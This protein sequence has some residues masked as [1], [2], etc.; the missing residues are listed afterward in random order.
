MLSPRQRHFAHSG[1]ASGIAFLLSELAGA[2]VT[3]PNGTVVPNLMPSPDYTET[4]IQAYFAESGETID[5]VAE[6]LA[7]PGKFSPLCNFEASLVLTVSNAEAG[8]AWYNVDEADATRPMRDD[9]LFHILAPSNV[10][11]ASISAAD[12]RNDLAYAGGYVGFAL[13]KNLDQDTS[14]PPTA[15]YYSEYRR[16]AECTAC[17]EPGHWKMALSFA[18]S[19]RSD[20]YYLAFEDWEGANDT[21]WFGNDGDFNDKV[22]KLVGISCAGGGMPC[23]TGGIGLC[24][25]GKTECAFDGGAP[26]CVPQYEAEDEL[27]DNVD[28]DCNGLVDDGQLCATNYACVRGTCVPRCQ[29]GEFV[30]PPDLNCSDDGY[31]FDPLCVDVICEANRTCRGGE[32]IDACSGIVCPLGQSCINGECKRACDGVICAPGS[33]CEGGVCIGT[34]GCTECLDGRICAPSGH[35]VDPGCETLTC[36]EGT[37]CVEGACV[38]PCS[39]AVCPGGGACVDGACQPMT[40]A[41]GLGSTGAGGVVVLG[42][43]GGSA[44]LVNQGGSASVPSELVGPDRGLPASPDAGCGCHLGR[45][46]TGLGFGLGVLG[47]LTVLTRRVQRRRA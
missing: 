13:T 42:S 4:S 39:V 28:N 38:D 19:L 45:P 16:N 2:A 22:F 10:A 31:C 34:C 1:L 3:E 8:I 33:V 11:N 15:I 9:E 24:G 25:V 20:T 6:A 18:S 43:L 46:G 40:G 30:C 17:V 26:R 47:M 23:E 32:C 7:E 5:A 41:G 27:C 35:C 36:P 37:G 12:I 21:T 29:A 44:P 14:T